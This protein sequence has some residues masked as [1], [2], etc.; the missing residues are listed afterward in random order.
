MIV[1]CHLAAAKYVLD[2]PDEA[3]EI[4][5]AVALLPTYVGRKARGE[6]RTTLLANNR[7]KRR[8]QPATPLPPGP[9]PKSGMYRFPPSHVPTLI[10]LFNL[11]ADIPSAALEQI[12]GALV[13][14]AHELEQLDPISLLGRVE[15]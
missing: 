6:Y 14:R 10:K 2:N 1:V 11:A 12:G 15:T 4:R 5:E 13:N 3:D 9:P 8:K 7:S